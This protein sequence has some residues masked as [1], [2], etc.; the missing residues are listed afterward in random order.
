MLTSAPDKD[1]N[2]QEVEA[3]GVVST[4]TSETDPTSSE[5]VCDGKG[6]PRRHR[7]VRLDGELFRGVAEA[8]KRGIHPV[9]RYPI[10]GGPLCYSFEYLRKTSRGHLVYSCSGCKRNGRTTSVAVM[11]GSNLVGDPVLLPH[12]CLPRKNVQDQVTRMVYKSCQ[13]IAKDKRFAHLKPKELWMNIADKVHCNE[14]AGEAE[15]DE[16]LLHFYRKG[17]ESRRQP[18]A[19][20]VRRLRNTHIGMDIVPQEQASSPDSSANI[21]HTSDESNSP[22]NSDLVLAMVATQ[23]SKT[24]SASSEGVCN[25][26]DE[27]RRHRRVRLDGELFRGVAEASKRGIHPVIRYPIPGGSLCYSFEYLRKTSRGHLVYSCSGCKR[28]GRTTSVAVI[29]GSNLVGD[30]VLLPHVCLPRKNVEDQVTRMVY[31]SCQEIV[32]DERLACLKPKELWMNIADKVRCNEAAGEA[33]RDEMLFHFYRKGY[34]SRRKPIARAARRLRN[35]HVG[36]DNVQQKHASSP[37]SSANIQHASDEMH[38]YRSSE[39]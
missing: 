23:T 38:I 28:N 10:P 15:R 30:P 27:P 12:V 37:D 8:S 26:K 35:T 34:E 36:M 5:E 29:N 22:L 3:S 16:M 24:V 9:I 17:Y 25:T 31:K 21:Q 6:K 33:E 13:E 20:A 19:R 32:K 11:N 2:E 1:N 18:I 4:Q 14:A 7:R 39:T